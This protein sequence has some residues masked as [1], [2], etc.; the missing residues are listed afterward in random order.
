MLGKAVRLRENADVSDSKEAGSGRGKGPRP[1]HCE[2]LN[3]LADVLGH[4]H[5][6]TST[7]INVSNAVS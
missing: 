3:A 7:S 5:G 6:L 4:L 1:Y 2:L